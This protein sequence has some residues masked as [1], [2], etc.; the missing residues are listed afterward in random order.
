MRRR[1]NAAT[2]A[3]AASLV[4]VAAGCGDGGTEGNDGTVEIGGGRANDHGRADVSGERSIAFELDDHYFEPTIL[5]GEGGQT[6]TLEAFNEG[7][8]PHTLTIDGTHTDEV[9]QPG[10]RAEIEVTFPDSGAVVFHC[11]FHDGQ[12]MRGALSVGGS[13]EVAG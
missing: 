6:V 2:L 8:A 3:L 5:E 12:G 10:D 9:L 11:H 4:L 1:R 13:L 7:D